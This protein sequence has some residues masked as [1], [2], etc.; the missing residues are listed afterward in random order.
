MAPLAGDRRPGFLGLLLEPTPGRLNFSLRLAVVCALTVLVVEYYRT[1]EPALTAYVAFFMSK[2][3][4]TTSVLL[5]VVFMLL[6]SLVIGGLILLTTAVIND[7]VWRVTAMTLV[8]FGLLFA[9]SASKLRPVGAIVALIAAYALDLL[10][11]AEIGELATRALLYVLLFIGVPAALTVVVSLLFGPAPRR[12]VERELAERL[13]LCA[14]ALRT[15]NAQTRRALKAPLEEGPGEIP[16]WLRLAG[17][18]KTSPSADLAALSQAAASTT[19]ILLLVEL[20]TREPDRLPPAAARVATAD[21]LDQM[22]A[23]LEAGGYPVEIVPPP[24]EEGLA[25]LMAAVIAELNGALGR[26]AEP[27]PPQSPPPAPAAKA[28]GGFWLP[29]AFTNPDHVRYALK[30]TAAA[31]F[32]YFVY[33]LLDWPGIHT[34][35]ITCYIVSLGT[36][37]ETVEK[38]SLRILGC[39]AGAAAGIAAIVWVT[40]HL[41][42]ITGLLAIVFPAALVSAWIAAGSPRISYAGFQLAFAFFLSVIQGSAP[43]FDMTIARD[44]V[45][46]I[47]FGNLVV[48]LLFTNVW[49]VSVARR[50]DPAIGALLRQLGEM[51]AAGSAARSRL[52]AAAQAQRVA[53]G[54]DLEIARY[55]PAAFRPPAAWLAGRRHAVEEIAALEGPLM[56]GAARDPDQSRAAAARLYAVADRLGGAAPQTDDVRRPRASEPVAALVER[57]VDDLERALWPAAAPQ[58]ADHAPA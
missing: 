56:L 25:P 47:L 48:Y 53:I 8:S 43:A 51:A 20:A 46:G 18:E 44:R 35:L 5:S 12:L 23:I 9:A 1:P 27:P 49:P 4:R 33:S 31:M 34:C 16:A 36:A 39:L 24:A 21:T 28:P 32:C 29:D 13:S 22:V 14:A 30:T 41:T 40:P 50:I 7:P 15:P 6:I 58:E 38:L 2:P 42:S 11:R 52:L 55:E 45:I 19:E 26:F 54:G 3:D 10:A 17:L 37:A 57:H